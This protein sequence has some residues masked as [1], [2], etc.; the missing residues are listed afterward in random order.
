MGKSSPK[1]QEWRQVFVE[2]RERPFAILW[3][4]SRTV[5][6]YKDFR[7]WYCREYWEFGRDTWRDWTS[8]K[9][10]LGDRLWLLNTGTCVEIFLIYSL[11][12]LVVILGKE[13]TCCVKE[14]VCLDPKLV[15]WCCPHSLGEGG[16]GD[17]SELWEKIVRSAAMHTRH[18]S[19]QKVHLW[20]I[21]VISE[22]VRFVTTM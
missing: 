9:E 12:W 7:S 16:F 6:K 14:S 3:E 5:L 1:E 19:K 18:V 10:K 11:T 21:I 22:H 20:H 4:E 15:L 13:Q 8:R 2:A 17:Q